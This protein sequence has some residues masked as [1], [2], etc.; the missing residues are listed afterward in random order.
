MQLVAVVKAVINAVPQLLDA[1]LDLGAFGVVYEWIQGLAGVPE[2]EFAP[3]TLGDLI[4]LLAAFPVTYMY[5]LITRS[6]TAQPFPGG[7]L[8]ASTAGDPEDD[9][10]SGLACLVTSMAVGF[11]SSLL[12]AIADSADAQESILDRGKQE[13]SSACAEKVRNVCGFLAAWTGLVSTGFF[14][15]SKDH[16]VFRSAELETTGQQSGLRELDTD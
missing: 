11:V 12:G 16:I 14:W 10:V 13:A 7:A 4:L 1:P 9:K 5:K 15:P 2:S 6:P 3:P 8:P